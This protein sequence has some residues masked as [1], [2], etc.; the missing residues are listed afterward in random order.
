ML[1]NGMLDSQCLLMCDA[2]GG[3]LANVVLEV[4]LVLVQHL[5]TAPSTATHV[6]L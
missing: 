1:A 5:Y 2:W 6:Y 3:I 4:H